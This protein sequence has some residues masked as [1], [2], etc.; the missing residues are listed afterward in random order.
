LAVVYLAGSTAEIKDESGREYRDGGGRVGGRGIQRER[1][2]RWRRR[3]LGREKS[4]EKKKRLAMADL[5]GE[6]NSLTKPLL[7]LLVYACFLIY[8]L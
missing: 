6:P 4:E 7:S 8:A 2:S 3:E 1:E 5:C